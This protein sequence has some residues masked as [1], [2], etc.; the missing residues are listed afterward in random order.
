MQN[1]TMALFES[2]G[3][4]IGNKKIRD[5]KTLENRSK[6]SDIYRAYPNRSP[7]TEWRG[8]YTNSGVTVS[9]H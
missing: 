1:K 9:A 8:G 7:Y 5:L 2:S 6:N 3:A 4:R